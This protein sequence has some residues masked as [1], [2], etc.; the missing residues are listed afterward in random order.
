MKV[1]FILLLLSLS[2]LAQDI[3]AQRVEAFFREQA[4]VVQTP[5]LEAVLAAGEIL[6][7]KDELKDNGG[8]LVD[9]IGEPGKITLSEDRWMSFLREGRDVRLLVLHELLR[10][11]G[12][13]DDN[14]LMSRHMIP[15][16]QAPAEARSY[17]DLRV[18]STMTQVRTKKM[19]GEG[20]GRPAGVTGQVDLGG[21]N[22]RLAQENAV[23]DLSEKCRVAG[24]VDGV[25]VQGSYSTVSRNNRNGFVRHEMK[26]VVEGTCTKKMSVQR[27]KSQQKAEGC[28]KVLLCRSLLDE[29]AIAPLQFEDVQELEATSETWRCL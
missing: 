16:I 4:K 18:A 21:G 25:S 27:P 26:I 6:V 13:N 3:R 29:G 12:L 9:A 1:F 11:A 19:T 15:L 10:M 14:Y 5:E 7:V 22:L 24:F 8:S 2:A 20:F 17:C 23:L 28:Q